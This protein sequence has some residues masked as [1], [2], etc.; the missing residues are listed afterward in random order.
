MDHRVDAG[1]RSVP[2]P[3]PNPGAFR[4]FGKKVV[5]SGSGFRQSA[6][7]PV[8]SKPYPIPGEKVKIDENAENHENDENAENHE[9]DDPF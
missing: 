3:Y 9:N 5:I 7:V 4:H 8:V 2:N 6:V 1:Y